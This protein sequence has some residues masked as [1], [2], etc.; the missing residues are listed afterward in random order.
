MLGHLSGNQLAAGV[1]HIIYGWVFFGLVIGGMFMIGARWA[2]PQPA[3]AAAP[4]AAAAGAR[5]SL[6]AAPWVVAAVLIGLMV[7]TQGLLGA[8]YRTAPRAA[9]ELALPAVWGE[10]WAA[11]TPLSDWQP[12][13][14]KPSATAGRS[15]ADRSGA[16]VAVWVGYYRDQDHERKLVTSTNGPVEIASDAAWAQVD[17]GSITIAG[18]SGPLVLRTAD[19]R[20]FTLAGPASAPRLRVWQLYWVGGRWVSGDLPARLL[21]VFH[22]LLGQGDD[23]AVVFVYCAQDDAQAS[24]AADARLQRFMAGGLAPLAQA[25]EAARASH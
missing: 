11:T 12:A 19:L 13:Y 14:R 15:Y 18:P 2:Q 17:Q 10:G 24:Q 8:L 5:G 23:G 25:L 21:Q 6:D 1:D 16:A 7:G 4:P 3:A 9:P 20:R 22:R